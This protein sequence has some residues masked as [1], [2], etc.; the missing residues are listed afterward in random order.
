MSNKPADLLLEPTKECGM[1]EMVIAFT[2]V[3][4]AIAFLLNRLGWLDDV[5]RPC[6]FQGPSGKVF[7]MDQVEVE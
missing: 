1:L 4:T 2:E 6:D 3:R 7:R 5:P